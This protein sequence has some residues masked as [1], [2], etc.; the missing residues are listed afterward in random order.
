MAGITIYVS[1]IL[2][3]GNGLNSPHKQ[4]DCIKKQEQTI[5]LPIKNAPPW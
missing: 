5:F 1:I 3:N 4:A 2:L